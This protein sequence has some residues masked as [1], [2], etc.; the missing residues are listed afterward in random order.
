METPRQPRFAA[1]IQQI[2]F[3]ARMLLV[4]GFVALLCDVDSTLSKGNILS[5]PPI[6]SLGSGTNCGYK[7]KLWLIE[8]HHEP[9]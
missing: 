7:S 8:G 5:P 4:A 9:V 6:I 3:C 1:G 2:I